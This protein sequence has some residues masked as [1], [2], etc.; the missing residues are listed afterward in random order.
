VGFQREDGVVQSLPFCKGKWQGIHSQNG[1]FTVIL[2]CS[3]EEV[4]SAK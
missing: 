3:V 2:K 1:N 4:D